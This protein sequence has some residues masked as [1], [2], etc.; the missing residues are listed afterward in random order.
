M[1][2]HNLNSIKLLKNNFFLFKTRFYQSTNANN[3]IKWP[4]NEVR[5]T[6]LDHFCKNNK[7]KFIASSSVIPR[8]GAGTYF[9]NAGMNQF[10]SII[11]GEIN[12][13]DII[14]YNKYIGVANSQ[15][16]IRIGGKHSDLDS[17]GKDDNHHTFFEMLGNWSFGKY[18][19]EQACKYA[20]ELLIDIYKLDLKRLYFTYFAGNPLFNLPADEETKNI[21]ISLGVPE[22]NIIPFGMKENFWEMDLTGPCGPCTEIHYDRTNERALNLL[23]KGDE[24]VIELWNLVFMQYNRLSEKKFIQLPELVVDTGMGL[25]RLSAVLNNLN[26]NYDIDMF[27]PI[28]KQIEVYLKDKNIH[29]PSINEC[30][31]DSDLKYGYRSLSDHIRTIS[32]SISDGLIPTRSGLGGYLKYLILKCIRISKDIFKIE[33]NQADFLCSLVIPVVDTLKNTYPQLEM[34]RERIQEVSQTAF[35]YLLNRIFYFR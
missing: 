16:C 26:S 11:L 27:T 2:R 29:L 6:F 30:S 34:D 13:G 23:N 24:R 3:A 15:K 25:E 12:A 31:Q 4:T 7:H 9:T 33:N 32:V 17:I 14:D 10:K 21:W 19:K 18:G 1:N 35:F 20:L 22:G 8:K 5:K 28:F